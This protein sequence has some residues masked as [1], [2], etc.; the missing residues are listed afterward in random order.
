VLALEVLQ[1]PF[2]L[3]FFHLYQC[4]DLPALAGKVLKVKMNKKIQRYLFLFLI[5]IPRRQGGAY[6][7]QG[8]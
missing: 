5:N 2:N 1:M 3:T 4:V 7:K 6:N 8:I